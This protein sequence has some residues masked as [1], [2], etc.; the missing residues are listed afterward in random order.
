MRRALLLLPILAWALTTPATAAGEVKDVPHSRDLKADSKLA[1]THLAP[2][3]VVFTS[4]G[5]HYCAKVK[6]EYLIPM[7]RDA[8]YKDKVVIRQV[9]V[10]SDTVLNG[11]DGKKL[12]EGQFAAGLNVF[13]VP[14]VKVFDAKGREVAKAIVG[15]LT[16]D[17]YQGYLDMAI[18]EG[19]QNIRQGKAFTEDH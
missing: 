1:A 17:F 19:S 9:Q 12:T 6:S 7:L 13:M 5:C 18:E 10:G 14:T 15:L 16:E 4:P 8:A 2:L 3:M 11:F